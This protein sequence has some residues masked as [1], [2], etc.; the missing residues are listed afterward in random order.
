MLTILPPL[1]QKED[2]PQESEQQTVELR[3]IPTHHA[4]LKGNNCNEVNT[5]IPTYLLPNKFNGINGIAEF[6]FPFFRIVILHAHQRGARV[7]VTPPSQFPSP[8][9]SISARA[10]TLLPKNKLSSVSITAVKRRWRRRRH[11]R[12]LLLRRQ[13]RRQLFPS[14]QLR[15]P[16]AAAPPPPT[17]T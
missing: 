3:D 5:V 16:A 17:T 14:L 6:K 15:P 2:S 9:R 11:R 1:Q 13:R 7:T 8:P 10:T 12:C 4:T